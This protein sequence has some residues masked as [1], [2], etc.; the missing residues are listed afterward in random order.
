MLDSREIIQALNLRH[1]FSFSLSF[2]IS[3]F[4]HSMALFCLGVFLWDHGRTCSTSSQRAARLFVLFPSGC[5][6]VCLSHANKHLQI[7]MVF[8]QK[9]S[10]RSENMNKCKVS[11]LVLSHC[12]QIPM[13]YSG[14]FPT[15]I[16][17]KYLFEH[18]Y[19]S[20]SNQKLGSYFLIK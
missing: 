12:F 19:S 3:W 1:S 2:W 10:Q 16:G 4:F 7:T 9:R 5:F 17:F 14:F 15:S 6:H 11:V 20:A 18:I 8:I 13:S